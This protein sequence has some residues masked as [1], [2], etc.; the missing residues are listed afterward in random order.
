M[1]REELYR[2][3]HIRPAHW[4]FRNIKLQHC[5]QV[6][7]VAFWAEMASA[8]ESALESALESTVGSTV[9][10]GWAEVHLL[11]YVSRVSP[12]LFHC[13]LGTERIRPFDFDEASPGVVL[14]HPSP[15]YAVETEN[16]ASSL[17][18][19]RCEVSWSK[20]AFPLLRCAKTRH[21]P[22]WHYSTPGACRTVPAVPDLLALP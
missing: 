15:F 4:R 5:Y 10:V 8:Q 20:T 18:G 9:C 14:S 11:L 16:L 6:V 17:L 3:A 13:Q 21:C 1:H 7:Q 12:D 2:N 22:F 19:L